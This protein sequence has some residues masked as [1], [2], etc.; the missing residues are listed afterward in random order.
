VTQ[1]PK[2]LGVSRYIHAAFR[3]K[4]RLPSR[5][6]QARL[7]QHHCFSARDK[8]PF[9]PRVRPEI[10]RFLTSAPAVLRR[11]RLR[12]SRS[13]NH[14][15]RRQTSLVR[16]SNPTTDGKFLLIVR[17]CYRVS[18][19]LAPLIQIRSAAN[20]GLSFWGRGGVVMSSRVGSEMSCT[21]R[22]RVRSEAE[23]RLGACQGW[24]RGDPAASDDGTKICPELFFSFLSL[25][26][27]LWARF[28]V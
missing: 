6:S 12:C 14:R 25:F 16:K 2:Q 3:P 1:T 26:F 11:P 20:H 8:K 22:S 9:F 5:S 15:E 17:V 19:G 23:P 21:G 28:A 13:T 18:R 4:Q 10:S 7:N 24:S 27:L